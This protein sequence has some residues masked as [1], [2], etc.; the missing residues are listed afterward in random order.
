MSPNYRLGAMVICEC[1]FIIC[2]KC[3]SLVGDVDKRTVYACLG[4]RQVK[5]VHLLLNISVTLKLL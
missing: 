5:I 2:N 4:T 3:T 1:R